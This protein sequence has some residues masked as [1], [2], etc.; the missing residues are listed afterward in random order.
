[1]IK[2]EKL[3]KA[4][5]GLDAV[6]CLSFSLGPG[7]VLGL[8]GPNGAGKTTTLRCLAGVLRPDVGRIIVGG[9]DMAT[10]PVEAKRR[11]AYLPDQPCFFE[12]LT[13]WEHVRF[14]AS[15]YGVSDFKS[16]A[17]R[18]MEG[19]GLI[20]RKNSLVSQFSR[21]MRQRLGLV[22]AFVH[23][24]D[25]L[26]LDEPMLGLDPRGMK[27]LNSLIEQNA[28]QGR[29]LVTSSHLLSLLQET[30]T[31][32]LLMETGRARIYGTVSE[33]RGQVQTQSSEN[34]SLEE[35]FF[36]VTDVRSDLR[37]EA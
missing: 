26:L 20:E 16:E 2:V 13:A 5:K 17:T 25:V 32:V 6:D 18:L 37:P 36:E 24:P 8:I 9:F 29:T 27:F 28:R 4:F 22:C 19:F 1:M 15:I 30:C 23:S 11:I 34:L 35:L 14:V 31:K 3:S 12:T 33:V 7:E 10:H 21:G